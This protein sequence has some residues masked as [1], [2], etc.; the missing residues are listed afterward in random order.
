ME[1]PIAEKTVNSYTIKIY[2]N[3]NP[4]NPREE[5]DNFGKMVCFHNRYLLGD[6]HNFSQDSFK[7][8][9][10]VN[11]KNIVCLKLYL[12][13]HSGITMSSLSFN[14]VWDSACVGLIYVTYQDIRKEYGVKRITKDIKEKVLNRL[15]GE[16]EVYNRYLTGQVYGFVIEDASGENIDSCW[17]YYEDPE[18]IIE[19]CERNIV[20][21]YDYQLLLGGI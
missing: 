12:Y 9:L 7:D 4:M 1:N 10:E 3:D 6:K 5:W 20:N 14:Y 8:F 13:D 11:E 19:D 17:G 16:I 21:H 15:K 18:S 2:Q